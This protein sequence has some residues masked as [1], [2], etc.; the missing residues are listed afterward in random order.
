MT[1]EAL[2]CSMMIDAYEQRAVATFDIPGVYLQAS[3]PEDKFVLLKLEGQFVTIMCE[4]NPEYD[5]YIIEENGKEVLYLRIKKALYGM[6]ES[7]LLWYELY[8]SVLMEMGFEINPYDMCVANKMINGKQCTIAWYVDDNKV[9]HIEQA[10]VDE[11]IEKIE[12][13]FPGLTV[14]RSNEQTFIGIKMRFM[15]E[16]KVAINMRTYWKQYK[17]SAK[18]YPG[19]YHHP[20][21]AG[22]SKLVRRLG[23]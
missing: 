13:R 21:P 22:Y 11:I 6:I 3:L 20:G 18:M 8:V 5:Q 1:L 16:K 4:V 17:I 19:W 14:N 7:A 12:Q 9:S 23:S 10:V 2:L 15:K